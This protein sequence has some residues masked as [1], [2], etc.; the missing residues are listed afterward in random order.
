MKKFAFEMGWV[1]GISTSLLVSPLATAG[2]SPEEHAR[3]IQAA[4]LQEI[5]DR[6]LN[7]KSVKN[8]C[9][10]VSAIS[11]RPPA[12]KVA[13]TFDDGPD[14]HGTPFI[15]ETLRR[16]GIQ[17]T[18]FFV[19]K[20]AQK[21]PELV[22]MVAKEG[23][24][25]VASHSWDHSNFH[26][27]SV[28][29]QQEQVTRADLLL[30]NLQSPRLFRYPFGNSTCDANTFIHGLGY[31]IVGWHVDSCDWGFNATGTV[32]NTNG[33]ICGVA[34]A[35]RSNYV[36]HVVSTIRK[37]NGGVVLMHEVQPNTLKQLDAIV[38]KL[39]DEGYSFGSL[40]EPD[41]AP[42]LF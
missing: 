32:S 24:M 27:L 14:E 4:R 17:A 41:F 36:E 1:L 28:P 15:L 31:K 18:F 20:E 10:Y 30:G 3:E 22:E 7:A 11:A 42:S 29:A 8:S 5:F 23:H 38:A 26:T 21:H 34:Q 9:R 6:A 39:L 19:G 40:D 35:N 25:I 2:Q 33:T 37:R 13:L 16:Y 12:K